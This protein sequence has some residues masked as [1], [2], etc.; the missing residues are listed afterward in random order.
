MGSIK[1]NMNNNSI[2]LCY[3]V[4]QS[5]GF[6]TDAQRWAGSDVQAEG[7]AG[8]QPNDPCDKTDL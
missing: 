7:R 8:K 3:S 2:R 4:L 6:S 1:N 5:Q